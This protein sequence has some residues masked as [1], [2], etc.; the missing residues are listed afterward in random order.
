MSTDPLKVAEVRK[1]E[2]EAQTSDW[3]QISALEQIAD[4]LE[5]IRLELAK[6]SHALEAASERKS[7]P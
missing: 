5:C 6:L 1:I 7:R 4:S 3:R 2:R